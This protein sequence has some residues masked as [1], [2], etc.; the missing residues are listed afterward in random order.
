MGEWEACKDHNRISKRQYRQPLFGGESKVTQK[1]QMFREV[2]CMVRNG[3]YGSAD[4]LLSNLLR[5]QIPQ[6]IKTLTLPLETGFFRSMNMFSFPLAVLY[7]V[8][9][10]SPTTRSLFNECMC[11]RKCCVFHMC[12]AV[13]F[14]P[15]EI[16]IP[17]LRESYRRLDDVIHA[18]TQRRSYCVTGLAVRT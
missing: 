5:R 9:E 7:L 4:T 17:L 13:C 14:H 6:N 8:R 16:P 15:R 3:K 18:V 10:E 12:I 11:P 2:R 1:R